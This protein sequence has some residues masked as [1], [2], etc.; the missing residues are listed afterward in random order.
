MRRCSRCGDLKPKTNFS[1]YPFG[2]GLRPECNLCRRL[3]KF[4]L[5][6]RD[7]HT[8]L[9]AQSGCCVICERPF[10]DALSP[11]IDHNHTTGEIRGLLCDRCNRAIGLA[12]DDI[13]ILSAA[14]EYL[15]KSPIGPI[16][17]KR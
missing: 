12:K 3:V 7:Y 17:A 13:N 11:C 9:I 16:E 8:I 1:K 6:Y 10:S 2:D 4:G 15:R 14:A 5:S